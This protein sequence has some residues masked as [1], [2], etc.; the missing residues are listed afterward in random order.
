MA[1][2]IKSVGAVQER[3]DPAFLTDSLSAQKLV[4]RGTLPSGRTVDI[5][6]APDG[7]LRIKTTGYLTAYGKK[8]EKEILPAIQKNAERASKRV[9]KQF[10]KQGERFSPNVRLVAESTISWLLETDQY[11]LPPKVLQAEVDFAL[12]CLEAWNTRTDAL[13]AALRE[14]STI[15]HN[16]GVNRGA[17]AEKVAGLV[18]FVIKEVGVVPVIKTA[19][20]VQQSP[21]RPTK[22]AHARHNRK[23]GSGCYGQNQMDGPRGCEKGPYERMPDRQNETY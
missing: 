12:D 18:D 2:T 13:E 3:V 14:C 23:I 1:R 21:K 15:A 9:K 22:K 20:V 16:V 7:T 17:S 5:Y 10:G 19:A 11:S 6:R 8:Y 4:T